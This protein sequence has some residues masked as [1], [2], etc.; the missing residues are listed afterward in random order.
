VARETWEETG[1]RIDGDSVRYIGSQPWPFPQSCM[2]AFSATADD[3]Q[4]LDI[5]EEELVSARWFDREDVVAAT[6]VEGA[7][8]RKDVAEAA[9]EADPSLNL[10]VPPKHVIART[11]IDT[12]LEKS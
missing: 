1:I 11:L 2:V 5:D 4:T 6:R 7:V 8:M 9:L 10:L 12:W 3:S